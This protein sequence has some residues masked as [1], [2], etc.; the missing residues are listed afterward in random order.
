MI[1]YCDDI[2]KI[3]ESQLIG[4]FVGWLRPLTT[5]KHLALLRGS[6]HFVAAVDDETRQVVGF[7]TALSDGVSAA[8]IPLLEVLP[9][10]QGRG[11]GR[12]LVQE[13]LCKLEGITNIDLTCDAELQGFYG[14]FGM[15]K[16]TGMVLRKFL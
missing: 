7:I 4:F 6:T 3:T 10:Y 5:E 16:A 15:R 2:N 1:I 8:F 11:I 13:I 14:R 12:E 9:A